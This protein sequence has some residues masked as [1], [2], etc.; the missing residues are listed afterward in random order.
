MRKS[1]DRATSSRAK[2]FGSFIAFPSLTALA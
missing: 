2:I 1:A